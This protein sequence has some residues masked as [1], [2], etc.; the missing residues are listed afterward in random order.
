MFLLE[1]LEEFGISAKR[2]ASTNGGEYHAECPSCG[3]KDRFC[4]WPNQGKQGRYWCRQCDCKGD[5]I[6]FCRDFFGLSFKEACCKLKIETRNDYIPRRIPRA[7]FSP[8]VSIP[9]SD[10]WKQQA[11]EFLRKCLEEDI[12]PDRLGTV[13]KR[14]GL[15]SDTAMK[16]GFAYNHTTIWES[17]SKWG[18]EESIKEDGRS[19]KLWLPS[20]LIIPTFQPGDRAPIKLKVRS[21]EWVPEDKLPKYVEISGSQ[22]QFSAF[23]NRGFPI[24]LVEAELDAILLQQEV[25][26]LCCSIA[27]GGA[28]KRPDECLHRILRAASLILFSLDF[29]EAG[30]KAYSFWKKTY[31]GVIAWPAPVGKSPSEAFLLGVSLREWLLMGIRQSKETNC[32]R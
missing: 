13:L 16:F 2:T 32:R 12:G 4:I 6:Q 23:G 24:V 19:R 22:R 8:S 20:G 5:A 7:S 1:L 21:S 31:P 17:R 11:V 18:L 29:D 26:D 9:P 14:R 28:S 25:G 10:V 30:K 27:L 15:T 3:G